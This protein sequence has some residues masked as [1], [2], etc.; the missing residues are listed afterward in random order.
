MQQS[1]VFAD[2]EIL[3]TITLNVIDDSVFETNETLSLILSGQSVFVN[4]ANITIVE[5]DPIPSSGVIQFSGATYQ[6]D[7]DNTQVMIT[8]TRVNGSSGAVTF[9][10]NTIDDSALADED[11][12][13]FSQKITLKAGQI[14]RSI[15]ISLLDDEIYEGNETFNLELSNLEGGA[16]FG[17]LTTT[18]VM[19]IDN[20]SA[21]LFGAIRLSGSSVEVSE[22]DSNIMITVQ[23]VNGSEGDAS[24]EYRFTDQ[25][26]QQGLDYYAVDGVLTFSDGQSTQTISVD[27]VDDNEEEDSESFT[28]TLLNPTNAIVGTIE[29]SI[30]Y[31]EDND[32]SNVIEQ[33]NNESGEDQ[34]TD[35]PQEEADDSSSG[36]LNVMFL[37]LLLILFN[38]RSFKTHK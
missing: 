34:N 15:S 14:S 12:V 21:P 3:K 17:E 5:D 30:I 16:V 23:R 19:L 36:S 31:I 22:S 9:D 28:L 37:M 8:I 29:S 33:D 25:S 20:E 32:E 38:R 10:V 13:E 26:A 24:I 11:F 27:I 35:Q 4:Q 7:E 2:G 6:V 18:S 1:L